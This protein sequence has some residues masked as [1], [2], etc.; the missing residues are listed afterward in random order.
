M[1]IL[2]SRLDGN[3]SQISNEIIRHPVWKKHKAAFHALM[4]LYSYSNMN[5]DSHSHYCEVTG[6]KITAFRDYFRV[7]KKCGAVRQY[8]SDFELFPFSDGED[9]TEVPEPCEEKTIVAEI[10]ALPKTTVRLPKAERIDRIK[11]AWDENKPERFA[12]SGRIHEGIKM[13]IDA[14]MKRVGVESGEYEQFMAPVLRAAA[15]VEKF[16]AG[17][18]P[19]YIFGSKRDLE[20]WKFEQVDR[21]Y[22]QGLEKAPAKKVVVDSDEQILA[23]V[24]QKDKNS[25][26]VRVARVSVP[27][28]DVALDVIAHTKDERYIPLGYVNPEDLQ[29]ANR[30]ARVQAAG[31]SI[32][33]SWLD[34]EVLLIAE[35]QN[36]GKRL[37]WTST[38]PIPVV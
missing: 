30:K 14:H 33:A 11:Q 22:R 13:A 23:Y 7:W 29:V 37:A 3:F 9:L 26:A 15:N 1:R 5:F 35:E 2:T 36:T 8:G 24:S 27:S 19:A 6:Q 16:G 34:H 25:E 4:E 31:I 32:D 10:E 38:A 12:L 21:L 20:D 18:G 28:L 17:I